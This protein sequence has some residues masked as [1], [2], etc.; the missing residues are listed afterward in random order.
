[1]KLAGG[2]RSLRAICATVMPTWLQAVGVPI[3]AVRDRRGHANL[4]VTSMYLH[5]LDDKKMNEALSKL[6]D[7]TTEQI[8]GARQSRVTKV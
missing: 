6:C 4:A 1:L 7:S 8:N 2:S 5:Y 3:T